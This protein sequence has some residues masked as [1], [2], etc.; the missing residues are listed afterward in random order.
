[1]LIRCQE[2]R[3]GCVA[4]EGGEEAMS[5]SNAARAQT[6][7]GIEERREGE[8]RVC[9]DGEQREP[10]M[11]NGRGNTTRARVGIE[12]L[13]RSDAGWRKGGDRA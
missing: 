12:G 3:S 11:R 5:S 6:R 13:R 9:D 7:D 1:M 2:G 8:D 10:K 4:N